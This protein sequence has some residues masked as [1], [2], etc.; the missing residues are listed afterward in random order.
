MRKLAL[1][2]LS[3]SVSLV[4]CAT[5]S[6]D[7]ATNY[8]SPIQ[9]QSYDCDQLQSEAARIQSRVSQLGGRLDEAASND[10]AIAGVGMI[11]FWP[12]LFALGGTKQQEAEYARLKGEYDAI[13]QSS[14][15]K[16]CFS[17]T[18]KAVRAERSLSEAEVKSRGADVN[19]LGKNSE[20]KLI[21]LKRLFDAGLISFE[22]YSAQ[23]AVI[24]GG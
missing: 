11:L 2:L 17:L 5:S 16:K 23:Q 9:F 15:N 24:L 22:V 10:K 21:E 3:I 20:E 12:A 14:I 4:G 19:S 18:T 1:T 6:K 7:V 8:V 13:Q